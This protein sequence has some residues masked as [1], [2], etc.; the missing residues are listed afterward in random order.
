MKIQVKL[1]GVLKDKNP[2]DHEL[3]LS[4]GDSIET[5]LTA[6]DIPIDSVQVFT[7]NGQI[8]RDRGHAL[9]EGDEL[10]VLPPVGGG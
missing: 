8:V 3:E 5:A 2:P 10:T 7:I 6:L 1:M 9:S 4:D